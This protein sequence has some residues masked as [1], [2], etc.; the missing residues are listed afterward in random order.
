MEQPDRLS[1]FGGRRVSYPSFLKSKALADE[2]SGIAVARDDL[3]AELFDFQRDITEWALRRGRSAVFADCGLGKTPMQLDWAGQIAG[4][5][6]RPV[7]ILAPLA[8]AKQTQRE[9]EKFG[10]SVNVC[11]EATDLTSGINITN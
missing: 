8:V 1:D 10:L 7:L 4:H 6:K 11:R 2:A 5:T 9:G 3:L